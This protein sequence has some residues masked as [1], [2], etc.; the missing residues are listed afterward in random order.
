MTQLQKI[1]ILM[2]PI[3]L[4]FALLTYG[5]GLGI[6]R[7]L[8]ATILLEPQIFGAAIILLIMAASAL[9]TEYFR[10]L[11][12]PIHQDE[13]RK[14]R[15]ELRSR[16]LVISIT[17]L[18][19]ATILAILLRSAGFVHLDT[20]IFL[21]LFTLLAL[22]NAVP[23]VR[24][25]NRG[26]GELSTAIQVANF[27][28]TLAFLFQYNNLHR[29]LTVYTL[30]LL[31]LALA[32]YLSTNF[33][34]YSN[35]L[36]FERRSLLVSLTWQRAVPIHNILLIGAYLFFVCIPFLGFPLQL[37]WPAL[38]SLPVAAYQVFSLRNLADGAKP[39]WPLF[40]AIA[41]AIFG[42]TAYSLSL[43]FWLH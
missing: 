35:D 22:M 8:G 15:A 20:A 27:S 24:L 28:P 17:F 14:E 23:P 33:P 32:Y 2:R 6:A 38:I 31:F 1:T 36:K 13:T 21:V 3:N 26:L 10:P 39:N 34:A 29:I 25:E 18:G 9:L 11:N 12:E 7:Y 42:L 4:I 43:T 30:P 37:V 16:L 41:T 40:S 5:L 19:T